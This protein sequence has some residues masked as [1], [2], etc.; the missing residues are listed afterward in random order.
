M[1]KKKM[2]GVLLVLVFV[3]TACGGGPGGDPPGKGNL[4]DNTSSNSASDGGDTSSS[5]S[6][7][8]SSDVTWGSGVEV[9]FTNDFM[10]IVTNGVPD[11]ETG[12]F[13]MGNN[14]NVIEE[15]NFEFNIPLNPEY[16]GIP[17]DL[18][19]GHI[20]VTLSGSVFYGAFTAEGGYA[21][22]LEDFDLCQAHPDVQGIYHYH[23][24]SDCISGD[25]FGYAWDGFQVWMQ[26]EADGSTPYDLDQCNGHEHDGEY[27]Y[28]LTDQVDG[29][30]LNCYMGIPEESNYAIG[31]GP[32]GGGDAP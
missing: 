1:M 2:F 14:P 4:P 5:G 12:D 13:P 32:G 23:Q 21:V 6:G 30:T 19:R 25:V 9:E 10:V 31:G 20:G 24:Q 27:H 28:H 3:F 8:T 11:H 26:T 17:I 16:T 15:Q 18:P 29:P 22:E 7:S